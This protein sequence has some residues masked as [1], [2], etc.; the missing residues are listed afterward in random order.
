M[1]NV[2]LDSITSSEKTTDQAFVSRYKIWGVALP[3]SLNTIHEIGHVMSWLTRYMTKTNSREY[4]TQVFH[5]DYIDRDILNLR[6]V[7][8]KDQLTDLGTQACP[9]LKWIIQPSDQGKIPLHL[10]TIGFQKPG[11]WGSIYDQRKI[12]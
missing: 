8:T 1:S 12:R 2:E 9:W 6:Y 7:V 3:L 5:T 11:I 10:F 4:D